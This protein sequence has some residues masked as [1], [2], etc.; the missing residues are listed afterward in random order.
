MLDDDTIVIVSS[1]HGMVRQEGKIN[2]NDFLIKEGYLVFKDDFLLKARQRWKDERKF[3]KFKMDNID[4]SKTKAYEVGA[5]QARI[6]INSKRSMDSNKH[7]VINLF[8]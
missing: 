8:Q 2:V 5:Y 1:D 7:T 4:W 6:Y 3:T